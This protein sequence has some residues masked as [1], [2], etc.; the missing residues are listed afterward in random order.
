[1]HVNAYILWHSM[2]TCVFFRNHVSFSGWMTNIPS[3]V[4]LYITWYADMLW[5]WTTAPCCRM[6]CLEVRSLSLLARQTT[7]VS[8]IDASTSVVEV[9]GSLA[10]VSCARFWRSI[11]HCVRS[12]LEQ[13][14]SICVCVHLWSVAFPCIVRAHH[15]VN[16]FVRWGF[17]YPGYPV[18]PT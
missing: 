17:R 9:S 10:Q 16:F 13:F 14:N 1:M 15:T 11:H 18:F 12:F 6:Q 2:P 7:K 4:Q 8:A 5:H 3:L